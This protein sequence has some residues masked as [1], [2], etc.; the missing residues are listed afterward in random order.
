VKEW[1]Y[2]H[3]RQLQVRR[4]G[5]VKSISLK[6]VVAHV[7][8]DELYSKVTELAGGALPGSRGFLSKYQQGLKFLLDNLSASEKVEYKTMA[9]QWTNE[10]PPAEI[11]SK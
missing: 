8:Q 3:G 7:K 10:P 1:H 5:Y 11:Q 9:D 6:Y 2:N 4:F